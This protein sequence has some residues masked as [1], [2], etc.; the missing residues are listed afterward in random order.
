MVATK[1]CTYYFVHLD[2]EERPIPGTMFGKPN[3]KK[4][5]KGYKC[6]EALLTGLPMTAPAGYVQCDKPLRYWY[7]V[8]STPTGG[9]DSASKVVAN[10]LIAVRGV[11]KG[12]AGRSCQYVEYKVFKPIV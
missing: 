9:G 12:P 3:S 6:R 8:K 7:Q 5:D 1:Q 2:S 10:S 11:P 4:I